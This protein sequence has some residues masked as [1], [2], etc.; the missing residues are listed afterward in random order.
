MQSTRW[1]KRLML[2]QPFFICRIAER[3]LV[4]NLTPQRCTRIDESGGSVHMTASIPDWCGTACFHGLE[5]ASHSMICL[6]H[7]SLCVWI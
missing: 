2:R 7:D 6:I 5:K 4:W 1:H 3:E